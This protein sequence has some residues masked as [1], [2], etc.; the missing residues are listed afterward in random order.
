MSDVTVLGLGLMGSAL[1]RVIRQA[2]YKIT[3]W[4]RTAEKMDPFIADGAKGASSVAY[5]VEASPVIVVCVDN[6]AVTKNL[7]AKAG[8][9][10]SL[11]GRAIV[12]LSTGT[13]RGAKEADAWFRE[14]GADYIDG[15]ILVLPDEVGEDD[16][17]ILLAGQKPVYSQVKP[18]LRCLGGDLRYFG[19]NVSAPSTLNLGWLCQRLG[20]LLGALHG[21]N[22]CVSE[23]VG[24]DS[25]ASLFPDSDRVHMLARTIHSG[26]YLN[27]SVTVRVWQAILER[28]Q[29]QADEAG[30]NNDFPEFGAGIIKKAIMAGY[31]EEDVSALFK[32]L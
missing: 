16:T 22:L 9:E 1:A 11:S 28:I 31:A 29:N 30:I 32:V 2:E 7:M 12:Q 21:V 18:L 19:E 3:V 10:P 6:Y 15:E 25:Y 8:V 14:R 24:V 13:P 23:G 4:N 27:P 17:Q 5:A 26:D 20:L